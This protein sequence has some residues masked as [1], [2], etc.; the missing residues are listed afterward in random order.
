MN[1]HFVSLGCARNQVDS[2]TMMGRLQ[3]AGWVITQE[4]A[5]AEVI[6]VNTCSFI[7]P[8]VDESIDTILALANYK[9]PV[10]VEG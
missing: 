8:A 1:V 3:S 7:E 10:C 9:K 6:V 2:E 5:D 4:P